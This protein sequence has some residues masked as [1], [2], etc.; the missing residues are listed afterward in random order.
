MSAPLRNTFLYATLLCFVAFTSCREEGTV[1]S[2]VTGEV[3]TPSI[4]TATI[5]TV[6]AQRGQEAFKDVAFTGMPSAAEINPDGTITIP[7]S[8]LDPNGTAVTV[9]KPGF[10]PE[11]RVLMPSAGGELRE[12]F[13]MEPKVSAGKIDPA[14]GGSIDLGENF[15]VTLAPN[16]IVTTADGAAYDGEVEVYVNHDAPEDAD[17]MLNSASNFLARNA[18][19][20][21]SALESYGMMDI[22]LEAPDGTPLALAASTPAEVRMPINPDTETGAPT[23]VPFWTLDP[24]GFWLQDGFATLAPGCYVVYITRSATCNIDVPHPVTRICGRFV[25]PAGLPLTHSPFLVSLSGGMSCAA[26]RVD[27]DGFFCVDVAAEVPLFFN[28]TDPCTEETYLFAVEPVD[29]NTSRD[30]GEITVDLTSPVF[31]AT[32]RDCSGSALPDIA[33]TEI[34]VGGNGGNGGEYFAPSNEGSTVINVVDCSGD[35]ML[36]QAFTNDYKAASRVIRRTAEEEM[37][38]EFILCGDLQADEYFTMTIGGVDIPVT[39]VAPI[40]WPD[41][42]EFDWLVRAAGVYEG[43]EYSLF[44]Q[45]SDPSAPGEAASAAIY[46]LLP[47]QEYGNGKVYVN[48]EQDLEIKG[49]T[50]AAD[51]ML[52]E[53][54]F[55]V[56]MNLQNDVAQ[57]VELADIDVQVAFRLAL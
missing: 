41:N 17:E 3:P 34:W 2:T 5:T 44:L 47:G 20:S 37:P 7:T 19:G 12:T 22:A 42:G 11:H 53:G 15:S 57:T 8:N 1:T 27:C 14:A 35:D 30:I 31:M 18:D 32:V 16:T 56:R 26:A 48:P 43:E 9:T 24:N 55:G 23:K 52:F 25:D 21:T 36:L 50:F 29:S 33:Q 49:T 54:N 46:R 28:V 39:E 10:W 38:T 13:V 6:N 40:Y 51:E 4:I 45:F